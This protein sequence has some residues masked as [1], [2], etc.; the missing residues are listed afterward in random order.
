MA[1]GLTA[2]A[3]KWEVGDRGPGLGPAGAARGLHRGVQQP[4]RTVAGLHHRPCGG[5]IHQI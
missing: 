2:S 3:L 5:A 1:P 4:G